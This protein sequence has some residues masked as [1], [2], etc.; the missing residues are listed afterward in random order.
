MRHHLQRSKQFPGTFAKRKS[1]CSV[2]VRPRARLR[3]VADADESVGFA[4]ILKPALG[5]H[6]SIVKPRRRTVEGRPAGLL[7]QVWVLSKAGR[8]KIVWRSNFRVIV[9][10]CRTKRV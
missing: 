10:Y 6:I 3:K 1:F 8:R 5:A 2:T 4:L 9:K 7:I